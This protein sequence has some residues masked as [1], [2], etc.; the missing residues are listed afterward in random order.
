MCEESPLEGFEGRVAVAIRGNC[1]FIEKC[2]NAEAGGATFLVVVNNKEGAPI[3][4]GGSVS[5]GEQEC[6]ISSVM[7]SMEDG[8]AMRELAFTRGLVE[9]LLRMR[10][11]PSK[12]DP[13]YGVMNLAEFSSQGPTADGRLKPDLVAPGANI[14][15]AG[16]IRQLCVAKIRPWVV[17]ISFLEVQCCAPCKW[18]DHKKPLAK[19]WRISDQVLL[20][21]LRMGGRIPT[22]ADRTLLGTTGA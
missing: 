5:P 19:L 14:W 9:E 2:V 6:T 11:A 3:S 17:L 15:S 12:S 8:D 7:L 21:Q 4:M 10:V 22:S 1:T 16:K 20:A 18:L 13:N